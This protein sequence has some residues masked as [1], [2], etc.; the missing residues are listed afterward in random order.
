MEEEQNNRL[1]TLEVSASKAK[2]IRSLSDEDWIVLRDLAEGQRSLRWLGTR[3]KALA[4]WFAAI[5][6]AYLLFAKQVSD[7]LKYQLGAG[8]H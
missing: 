6:G 1:V 2:L 4:V 7:W 8:G 5:V 3:L